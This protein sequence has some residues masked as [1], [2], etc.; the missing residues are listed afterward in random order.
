VVRSGQFIEKAKE[1]AMTYDQSPPGEHPERT[2]SAAN[3]RRRNGKRPPSSGPRAVAAGDTLARPGH[4]AAEADR[5]SR[6]TSTALTVR[7]MVISD[8]L[9]AKKG[10]PADQLLKQI[11]ALMEGASPDE[12]KALRRA[13]FRPE[14][15]ISG[16]DPDRPPSSGPGGMLVQSWPLR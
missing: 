10:T 6:R 8:I 3:K 12:V 9:S 5:V 11:R 7:K 16:T 13:L 1:K 4:R 15:T 14:E 2:A